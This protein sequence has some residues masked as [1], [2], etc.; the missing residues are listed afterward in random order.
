[1][2]S[3]LI[4][5]N[6]DRDN[7]VS[8]YNEKTARREKLFGV[9]LSDQEYEFIYGHTLDGERSTSILNKF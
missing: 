2:I 7:F 1:M 4:K 5:W 3:S 9:S 6:H 8:N